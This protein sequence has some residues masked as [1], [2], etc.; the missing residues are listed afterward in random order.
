MADQEPWLEQFE[1]RRKERE[2]AD[3]SFTLLGETL[4]VKANVAP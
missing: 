2:E 4:V 1:A 3:R